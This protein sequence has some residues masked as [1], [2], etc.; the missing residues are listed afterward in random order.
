VLNTPLFKDIPIELTGSRWRNGDQRD[1]GGHG[2]W[3]CGHQDVDVGPGPSPAQG[4]RAGTIYP[5]IGCILCWC[6]AYT[7]PHM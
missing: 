2:Q 4:C 1:A 7:Y 3:S 6:E 5:C